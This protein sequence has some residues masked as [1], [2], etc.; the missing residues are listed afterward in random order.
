[1]SKSTTYEERNNEIVVHISGTIREN[2]KKV[3]DTL[4][5][6]GWCD[7]DNTAISVLDGFIIGHWL[8]QLETPTAK[9]GNI[10]CGGIGEAVALIVEAV[11]TGF[12]DG[13]D[14]SKNRKD[15]LLKAFDAAG[16]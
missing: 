14:E 5:G 7:T 9:F 8:R 11:D 10:K 2:L 12:A 1:M 6:V 13:T 16:F 3:A 4:N 15:E